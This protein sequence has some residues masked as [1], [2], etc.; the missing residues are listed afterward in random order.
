[1][2][3]LWLF[4]LRYY[5]FFLFLILEAFAI[6]LMI[7][8]NSYHSASYFNSAN[9]ISADVF[10]YV[11][12]AKSFVNLQTVNDSLSKENARLLNLLLSSP[13]SNGVKKIT[14]SDSST[15]RRYSYIEAKVMNNSVHN[16]NNYLTL[17]RGSL[18]GVKPKMGVI[19][20]NGIVGTVKDVN[21]H[22]CTVI[23]FLHK[24]S[25]ISA[26]LSATKD[27]GSLVWDGENPRFASLKDIPTHVKVKLGDSVTTTGYSQ[28]FPENIFVGRV[29]RCELKSG[30][31]FY[32]IEVALSTH[33]STLRYVYIVEDNFAKEL[34]DLESKE[35][36]ND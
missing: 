25:R 34:A 36:G 31:N 10:A 15:L 13:Y 32:N 17:D 3:N 30:D 4:F 9:N 33:F 28:K 26:R 1:M 2:R 21:E 18:Q 35:V 20:G 12:N 14:K 11:S 29:V 27:F 7:N 19:C 23:S 5:A 24:D 22:F 8:N 16:R 6:V